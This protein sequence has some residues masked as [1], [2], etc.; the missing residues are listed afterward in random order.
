[1]R[2]RRISIALAMSA[3][4]AA[5]LAAAALLSN[6]KEDVQIAGGAPIAVTIMGNAFEDAVKAGADGAM[7]AT[8][9]MPETLEPVTERVLQPSEANDSLLAAAPARTQSVSGA[10]DVLASDFEVIDTGAR[11]AE[12]YDCVRS[13]PSFD[14]LLVDGFE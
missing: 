1:M 9:D 10:A 8:E 11:I 2:P 5:H 13:E 6:S 7:Q 14:Q 3:S 4:V 12:T